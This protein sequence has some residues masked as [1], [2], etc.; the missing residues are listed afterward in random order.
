MVACVVFPFPCAH[1]VCCWSMHS[2]TIP[3]LAGTLLLFWGVHKAAPLFAL[4]VRVALLCVLGFSPTSPNSGV[5]LGGVSEV[6]KIDFSIILLVF[7]VVF[8]FFLYN[9]LARADTILHYTINLM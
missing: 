1:F 4:V 9:S 6:G 7:C 2:S 3:L 8:L 5:N